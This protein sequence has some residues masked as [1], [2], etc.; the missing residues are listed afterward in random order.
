[1]ICFWFLFCSRVKTIEQSALQTLQERIFVH[2]Q[3][4]MDTFAKYDRN[5][6]GNTI[7]LSAHRHGENSFWMFMVAEGSCLLFCKAG[8]RQSLVG[9]VFSL[10]SAGCLLED[11]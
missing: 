6:T 2:K 4:L 9:C 3:K 5:S 7:C 10:T 1:M 11:T 8:G